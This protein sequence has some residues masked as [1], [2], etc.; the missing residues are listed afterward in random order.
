MLY[1]WIGWNKVVF[2]ICIGRD[3]IVVI[4]LWFVYFLLIYLEVVDK[5]YEEFCYFEEEMMID[6]SWIL[7]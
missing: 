3:I 6:E 1:C 7:N 2:G 5:V 4:L